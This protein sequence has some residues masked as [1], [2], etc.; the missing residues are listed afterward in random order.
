MQ[1]VDVAKKIYLVTK[2]L[3]TSHISSG[4]WSNIHHEEQRCEGRIIRNIM[5]AKMSQVK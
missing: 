1:K 4:D 5:D 3:V 2:F